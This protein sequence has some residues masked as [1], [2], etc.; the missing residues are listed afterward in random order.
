[1]RDWSD[2]T[3]LPAERFIA[4]I[5]IA[6]GKFFDW[7]KR[8]GKANE[9]NALIP[10]DHW[11]TDDE[12]QAII[13]FHERFPL[14]GYRRL[15]FMMIDQDIVAAS[16]SSVYRVLS[17]AG[18]LD[19]VNTKPSKKGTGFEQ[20]EQAHQHWHVD[21]AY[22]NLGG[23]FYYLCSVLDGASRAV[24]HW[25]IREAMTEVDI[26]CIIQ[27][28]R[29]QHPKARPRIITDNGPQFIAK[30]FKEF[31]RLT[32]MTH[33][34]TS[35][36]YPQSNGKIERWHRTLKTDA[37]RPGQPS[38]LDEARALVSRW[39][40]HY[41]HVRLHSALGYITPADFLAGRSKDIWTE[42]DR[43]LELAR[44]LRADKRAGTHQ[45]AA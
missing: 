39:V 9:H 14:E 13:G 43:K 37:I 16:P 34:R 31:I 42:R 38:S 7:R 28:A 40:R 18:L 10:R 19:R 35:P 33:V 25:E 36:Y 11:L 12:K 44:K 3:E 30:D 4:W 21:V 1:M 45:A 2:K 26:E 24:V 6:R 15:T 27:Q 5:D 41:N 32:G 22:L 29:E 8:Y 17:K 20:P 23:T